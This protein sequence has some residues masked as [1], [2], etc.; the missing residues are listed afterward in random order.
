MKTLSSQPL[1]AHALHTGDKLLLAPNRQ[2]RRNRNELLTEALHRRGLRF[3][4]SPVPPIVAFQQRLH[5][6]ANILMYKG[7]DLADTLDSLLLAEW[8]AGRAPGIETKPPTDTDIVDAARVALVAANAPADQIEHLLKQVQSNLELSLST[9]PRRVLHVFADAPT[10][11]PSTLPCN[12]PVVVDGCSKTRRMTV[13]EIAVPD[14]Y[15]N[16]HLPA[17]TTATGHVEARVVANWAVQC[18]AP[19]PGKRLNVADATAPAKL[20]LHEGVAVDFYQ[21]PGSDA[22]RLDAAAKAQDYAD[23]LRERYPYGDILVLYEPGETGVAAWRVNRA[24]GGKTASSNNWATC[25][26]PGQKVTRQPAP[27]SDLSRAMKPG[28]SILFPPEYGVNKAAASMSRAMWRVHEDVI[29]SRTYPD[30]SVRI[31][32]AP[33]YDD[34][35]PTPPQARDPII[36]PVNGYDIKVEAGIPIPPKRAGHNMRAASTPCTTS[37]PASTLI[38][39]LH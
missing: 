21:F 33:A 16:I 15:R 18:A 10:P 4:L 5:W 26:Q 12:I 34:S 25:L 19:I 29:C 13:D 20:P 38:N 35:T 39:C 22:D 36:V 37:Q 30:G 28:D 6:V 23:A 1:L 17:G 3:G 9:T 2:H 11:N 27:Y 8:R 31:W 32:R 24:I 7:L 14:E